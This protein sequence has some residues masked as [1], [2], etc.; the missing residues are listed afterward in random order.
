LRKYAEIALNTFVN[1]VAINAGSRLGPVPPSGR[2][3]GV[4]IPVGSGIQ[5]ISPPAPPIQ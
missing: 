4:F 5:V 3:A 2:G 1:S